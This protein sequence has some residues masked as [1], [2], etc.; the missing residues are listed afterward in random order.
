MFISGPSFGLIG[1]IAGLALVIEDQ[2]RHTELVMYILPK[3]MESA[4]TIAG[5]SKHLRKAT[6]I[7]GEV[8]VSA[9]CLLSWGVLIWFYSLCSFELD[10]CCWGGYDHGVFRLPGQPA[11]TLT[12]VTEGVPMRPPAYAWDHRPSF[13]STGGAKLMRVLVWGLK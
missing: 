8:I 2:R 11:L 7:N 13:V 3:A 12:L 9:F 5:G 1:L 10:G 6:S 4:W